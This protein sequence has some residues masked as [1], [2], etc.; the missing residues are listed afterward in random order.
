[1]CTISSKYGVICG[2][3]PQYFWH[4]NDTQQQV[5]FS[6][7]RIFVFNTTL[8][9]CHILLWIQLEFCQQLY[10]LYIVN[11]GKYIV[12]ENVLEYKRSHLSKVKVYTEI[13]NAT[14]W[15]RTVTNGLG[16]CRKSSLIF[17]HSAGYISKQQDYSPLSF[18]LLSMANG[19]VFTSSITKSCK[20]VHNQY[21]CICGCPGWP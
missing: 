21:D 5:F 11:V 19:H 1:M 13:H 16:L 10:L 2:K 18:C 4:K 14:N 12:D 17:F 9:S 8:L 6:K 7:F 20:L 15:K 3:I